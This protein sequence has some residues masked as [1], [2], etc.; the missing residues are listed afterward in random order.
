MSIGAV[1]DKGQEPLGWGVR[2]SGGSW[3]M[4]GRVGV[5]VYDAG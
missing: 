3:L 5:G 2:G 1:V 4:G